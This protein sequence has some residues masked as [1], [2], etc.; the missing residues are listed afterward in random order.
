[1]VSEHFSIRELACHHCGRS[2]VRDELVRALEAFRAEVSKERGADTAVIVDDAYRCPIHNRAVGGVQNSQHL[3][4]LA[5]DVKVSGM[6]A[7]ELY[8]IALRVPEIKGLGVDD[9]HNYLHIDVRATHAVVS[10]CYDLAGKQ[11]K[12]YEA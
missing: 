12:F 6:T 5:A 2:G 9:H 3:L 7:R 8:K 4:G 1:M 10:W 11:T